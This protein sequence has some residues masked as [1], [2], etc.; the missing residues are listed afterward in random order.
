MQILCGFLSREIARRLLNARLRITEADKIIVQIVHIF[1]AKA[2]SLP[3]GIV[4]LT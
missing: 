1:G 4:L 2:R 3:G